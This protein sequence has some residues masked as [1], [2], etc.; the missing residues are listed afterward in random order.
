M[1]TIIAIDP[2]P[3]ESAWVILKEGMPVNFR[4]DKNDDVLII[5]RSI[6]GD[7]NA[8]E[9]T[10]AIEQVASM[11]MAVG[12]EVFETVFWSG[13]FYQAYLPGNI[14]RIPRMAVKMYL[15]NDS[16]AKDGNIR[17]ALIDKFGG[18]AEIKKGG[19]LYQ[20]SGDVWAALGVAITAQAKIEVSN[21][22][23]A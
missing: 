2:G 8:S 16:R 19:S 22:K 20:I 15:C 3:T 18:K 4:K 7:I 6:R 14:M 5:L 23:R 13:R 11:G 17:Q 12:E 1:K 9:I 21:E 10:L